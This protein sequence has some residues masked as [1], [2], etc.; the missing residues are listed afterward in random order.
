MFYYRLAQISLA[1]LALLPLRMARVTG[2]ALARIYILL[3]SKRVAIAAT[4]IR[5]CFPLLPEQEQKHLVRQSFDEAG[6]WVCESGA[7]WN[8][9]D[10][11]LMQHT[12]ERNASLLDA[13]AGEGNG[14]IIA[15]LH[16]GNWEAFNS[17]ISSR[18]EFACLYKH[19]HKY[20]AVS[21]LI[22]EKRWRRGTHMF[23]A[24][25]SGVRKLVK[26]LEAGKIVGLLPDHQPT[27]SM[28]VFA[29]F[30]GN[31]A[32]TGTLISSL[33]RR[34]GTPVITAAVLRT[35]SGFE[36][37]YDRVED[38]LSDDAVIAATSLNQSIE[39][40]ILM[41]PEQFQWAYG[42]F[43]KQPNGGRSPYKK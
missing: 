36:V 14:V 20:P 41:A 18:F 25:R 5:L 43:R 26:W 9:S 3:N 16:M 24:D 37:V 35:R 13:A 40:C 21:E 42:R 7:I 39:R 2:V 15:L 11:R 34:H 19:D 30:F 38:Q 6:K 27:D 17:I 28:G 1:L 29:P 10:A 31:P 33:A 32:L 12:T 22:R 23:P 8:W 4:N